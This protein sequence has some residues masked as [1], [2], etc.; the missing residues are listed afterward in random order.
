[1][2][3]EI[4]IG[5]SRIELGDVSDVM[6]ARRFELHLYVEDAD[7]R[8]R[9]R[10]LRERDRSTRRWISLRRSRGRDRIDGEL[11]YIAT[12]GKENPPAGFGRS[13]RSPRDACAG[14]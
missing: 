1:M 13:R 9:V 10:W 3:S 2:H 7:A 14:A 6:D 11:W 5:D 4:L 12:H 8:M